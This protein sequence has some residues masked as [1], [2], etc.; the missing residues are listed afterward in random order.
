MLERVP[1]RLVDLQARQPE[2]PRS[3]MIS[4]ALGRNE[5]IRI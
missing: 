1:Y 5:Q 4:V 3:H 2:N